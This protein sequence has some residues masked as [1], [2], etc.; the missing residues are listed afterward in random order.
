MQILLPR[1]YID[2]S[3]VI[4]ENNEIVLEQ[5]LPYHAFTSNK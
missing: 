5:F 4:E 3:A 2:R 1:I